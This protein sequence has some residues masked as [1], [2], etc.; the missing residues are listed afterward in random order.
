MALG[1]HSAPTDPGSS[2]HLS[3]SAQ[4][5]L[6]MIC[7]IWSWNYRA[8]GVGGWGKV[9]GIQLGRGKAGSPLVPD[10]PGSTK[11]R[12][13]VAELLRGPRAL[14]SLP[15]VTKPVEGGLLVSPMGL[16]ATFRQST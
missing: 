1:G 12:L 7:S 4:V 2:Q 15:S 5:S 6:H 8:R 13:T 14:A 10:W 16:S 3:S 11:P 9:S